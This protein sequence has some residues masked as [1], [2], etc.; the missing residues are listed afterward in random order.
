LNVPGFGVIISTRDLPGGRFGSCGG[1]DAESD[2]R[3]A[4]HGDF[5][6]V[7]ESGDIVRA[8]AICLAM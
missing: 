1:Q 3:G 8:R 4:L 5:I 6:F 7:G 2:W